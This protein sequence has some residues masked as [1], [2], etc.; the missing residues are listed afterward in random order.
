MG[1]AR[2]VALTVNAHRLCAP[3]CQVASGSHDNGST[4][5]TFSEGGQQ[6]NRP[7]S[8][9]GQLLVEGPLEELDEA[10]EFHFD[11]VTKRLTLWHNASSGTPPPTDGSLEV[12]VIFVGGGGLPRN[13]YA[14][15]HAIRV[16]AAAACNL[17]L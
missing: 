2:V 1:V 8:A 16:Q 15:L 10:N 13:S 6:C 7:E 4:T 12:H 17:R 3:K 5:F 11:P 14:A 9:H